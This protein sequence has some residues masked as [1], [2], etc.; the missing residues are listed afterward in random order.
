M[1]LLNM[2][3]WGKSS[4]PSLVRVLAGCTLNTLEYSI[5]AFN[6]GTLGGVLIEDA[7]FICKLYQK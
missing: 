4:S 5:L 3:R 1:N 2:V 6:F 7:M